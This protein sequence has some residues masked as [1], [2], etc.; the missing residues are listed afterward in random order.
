ML[1]EYVELSI[2][3][4]ELGER[5]YVRI[6]YQHNTYGLPLQVAYYL[7]LNKGKSYSLTC[8]STHQNFDK[9]LPIFQKMINSFTIHN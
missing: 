4:S 8:S 6:I 1:F 9:Y 2:K 7:T 3:Y 5:K